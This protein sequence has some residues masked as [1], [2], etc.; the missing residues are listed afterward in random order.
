QLDYR[1]MV[2]DND[3][4]QL[5]MTMTVR[6]YHQNDNVMLGLNCNSNFLNSKDIKKVHHRLHLMMEKL[7]LGLDC[8][9]AELPLMDATERDMLI[10]GLNRRATVQPSSPLIHQVFEHQAALNPTAMAAVMGGQ[11]LSYQSLNQ[12]A[13][14]LA[15]YLTEQGV[16]PG[17]L[18]GLMLN[19]SL[20]MLVAML[21]IFK[22]GGAYVPLDPDYPKDR[23]L[24]MI[25]DSNMKVL[26]SHSPQYINNVCHLHIEDTV[27]L[28]LLDDPATQNQI[29]NYSDANLVAGAQAND[30][31]YVIYTSGSTGQPKGV[32][33]EHQSLA[34]HATG[35]TAFY[36]I[37]AQDQLLQFASFNVDTSLEQV[38]VA[39]TA[40]ACLHLRE[41][42]LWTASQFYQ[43]CEQ[44]HISQVDLPPAYCIQLLNRGKDADQFW[45][46][47]GIRQVILGGEA[48]NPEIV[49]QWHQRKL[50]GRCELINAYGPTETTITA[51]VYRVEPEAIPEIKSNTVAI[52]KATAGRTFYI[53]DRFDCLE[54]FGG[55]GELLIGGPCLARGYLN[56]PEQTS[57]SFIANP[58]SSHEKGEKQG[59]RLYRTGDLVRYREDGNLVFLGR[60]DE[61][62]KIRGFRV[63]LGEIEARLVELQQVD[64][65]A[66]TVSVEVEPAINAYIVPH[67]N[68]G[69]VPAFDADL[70]GSIRITTNQTGHSITLGSNN[71]NKTQIQVQ[72]PQKLHQFTDREGIHYRGLTLSEAPYLREQFDL[73]HADAWP[74]Y[75]QGSSLLKD[76]WPHMY[77]DYPEYQFALM[78]QFDQIVVIGNSIAIHWDGQAQ[79][80]PK[81]WDGA[82]AQGMAE[83]QSG[84]TG[85]TLVVLAGIVDPRYRTR[86][87]SNLILEGFK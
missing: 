27:S 64:E 75:F 11:L 66:V 43:Y 42:T 16:G 6:D 76:L 22:A 25:K 21:A 9:V 35:M 67:K 55:A 15:F 37:T 7:A 46:N 51:S 41:D 19:R 63:E 77:Q 87:L 10:N 85:N 24:F 84:I 20:D 54:P 29:A 14:R 2:M 73:I 44:N 5:P 62:V 70:G 13:N 72:I 83:Y 71:S 36:G 79:N 1:Y 31:A 26:L 17:S 69:L 65:A 4:E 81:G 58:Y 68:L 49:R 53:H 38:I 78:E 47:T 57:N 82:L 48:L 45:A 56:N 33:I 23:L 61:Q 8:P 59:E 30:L 74:G 32:M 12:Q 86:K 28:I 80:L 18:V 40:G 52:G 50:F 60:I 34:I 39:F 3:F